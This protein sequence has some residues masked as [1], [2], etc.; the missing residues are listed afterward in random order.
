MNKY[1]FPP[2]IAAIPTVVINHQ[3]GKGVLLSPTDSY[4][5]LSLIEGSVEDVV[6]KAA[7]SAKKTDL[8]TSLSRQ[9][10]KSSRAPAA[11]DPKRRR[12]KSYRSTSN[13]SKTAQIA[14][15][16]ERVENVLTIPA[17][18]V[19]ER[20][21]SKRRGKTVSERDNVRDHRAGASDLPFSKPRARPA[22]CASHR[23]SAVV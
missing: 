5:Q 23:Y 20:I 19:E 14:K 1:K 16:V 2:M 22:S 13:G 21:D 18:L 12:T 7:R 11:F 10:T 15:K 17:G 6:I 3:N 8:V 9:G 4:I